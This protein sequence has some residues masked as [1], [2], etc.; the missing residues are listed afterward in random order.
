MISTTFT[1]SA[2]LRERRDQN[3]LALIQAHRSGDWEAARVLS[4]EKQVL[5]KKARNYCWC[6]APISPGGTRSAA[7]RTCAV[8]NPKHLCMQVGLTLEEYRSELVALLKPHCDMKSFISPQQEAALRAWIDAGCCVKT[9]AE[10]LGINSGSCDRLLHKIRE[11]FEI[12]SYPLL[13]I[14]AERN[15]ISS[16]ARYFPHPVIEKRPPVV[17]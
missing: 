17:E 14:W 15:G 12:A 10:Q 4:Q 8:H 11:K 9:A 1:P 7:E 5:K 13:A 16:P 2:A 3:K 6:G